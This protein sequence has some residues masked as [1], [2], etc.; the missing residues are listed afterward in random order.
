LAKEIIKKP[1]KKNFIDLLELGV[2]A[3]M[4]DPEKLA[5]ALPIKDVSFEKRHDI[6]RNRDKV[7]YTS[8][9]QFLQDLN[10]WRK[11]EV[12]VVLGDK[13]DGK[14]TFSRTILLDLLK[15]GHR[16]LIYLSEDEAEEYL[17]DILGRELHAFDGQ[18]AVIG[19]LNQLTH[20]KTSE[21]PIDILMKTF[22]IYLETA[23]KTHKPDFLVIDNISTSVVFDENDKKAVLS[24]Y[25]Y[26]H[27][28]AVYYSI[29]VLFFSHV[30]SDL[31]RI[32]YK[33]TDIR[34]N[35]SLI[36]MTENTAALYKVL[37]Q[38]PESGETEIRSAFHW[39]VSRKQK[40]S[41][42]KYMLNFD[43]D[44]AKFDVAAR[45]EESEFQEFYVKKPKWEA[46][47]TRL[48]RLKNDNA[49]RRASL[50]QRKLELDIES[51]L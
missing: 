49:K 48:T 35:K 9:F 26:L 45:L 7:F 43:P 47:K 12:H 28:I 20:L 1:T 41:S 21:D 40:C 8:D 19:E 33:V 29:P 51:M 32:P 17:T 5:R 4:S 34:G 46:D 6:L 38:D 22:V 10:G 2:Q 3:I 27:R 18:V 13:G 23:L 42:H 50:K 39:I 36:N 24:F 25:N 37:R 30:K 31:K 16:P 14:S 15:H 11:G 44:V